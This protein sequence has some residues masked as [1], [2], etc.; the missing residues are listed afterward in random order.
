MAVGSLAPTNDYKYKPVVV[1][2]RL[3]SPYHRPDKL[4]E[5]FLCLIYRRFQIRGHIQAISEQLAK[6]EE[7][8]I[9]RA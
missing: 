3:L 4:E 2:S 6:D 1:I 9:A 5:R 7:I 8:K